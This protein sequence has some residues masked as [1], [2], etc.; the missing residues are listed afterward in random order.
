MDNTNNKIAVITGALGFIGQA[1]A[2]SLAKDG[3]TLALIYRKTGKDA[4]GEILKNLSGENHKSYECNLNN[5]KEVEKVIKDIENDMGRI[6]AFIHAAGTLPI[7]KYIHLLTSKEVE[8]SIEKEIIPAFNFL[9]I[10]ARNLKDKK[11][12]VIIGITTAGVITDK[13][14]KARGV[15][16]LIKFGIQ[17]MLTVLME[18]MKPYGVRVYSIAP[19]VVEGGLNKN[20]PKAFLDMV[21]AKTPNNKLATREDIAN[22]ISSLC[23][24]VENKLNEFT[25]LIAPESQ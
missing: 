15:Y 7:Q 18:E 12:G 20:T 2:L 16:S 10:G 1:I 24:E 22:R 25:I 11:E 4:C 5:S 3:F 14:T 21:K 6:Y 9:S 17:G 13:N 23:N 8:E 19:G